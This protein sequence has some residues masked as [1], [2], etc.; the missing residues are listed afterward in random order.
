MSET[1]TSVVLISTIEE[2]EAEMIYGILQSSEIAARVE[3]R[4]SAGVANPLVRTMHGTVYDILVP[5]RDAEK[6]RTLL[7]SYEE[8]QGQISDEELAAAADESYDPLV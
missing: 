4:V 5:A 3:S 8:G 6:A 2:I 1:E 7:D